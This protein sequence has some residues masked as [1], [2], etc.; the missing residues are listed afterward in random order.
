MRRRH[1]GTAHKRG[2]ALLQ[3]SAYFD[4]TGVWALLSSLSAFFNWRRLTTNDNSPYLFV[5][6]VRV[7]NCALSKPNSIKQSLQQWYRRASGSFNW[8]L[9]VEKWRSPNFANRWL[10]SRAGASCHVNL[11]NCDY[12]YPSRRDISDHC[13]LQPYRKS[14]GCVRISS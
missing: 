12:W 3:R 11:N 10:Q 8:Y 1:G 6:S 9:L 5:E 13:F 4:N 7:R 2:H 14:K